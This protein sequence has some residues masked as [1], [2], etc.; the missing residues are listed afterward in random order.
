MMQPHPQMQRPQQQQQQQQMQQMGNM[1]SNDPML[2][3]LL[4]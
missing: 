4:G 1:Q 2:R 3:E